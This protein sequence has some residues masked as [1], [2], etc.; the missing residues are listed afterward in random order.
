[1]VIFVRL[2]LPN[3]GANSRYP[4]AGP[5]GAGSGTISSLEQVCDVLPDIFLQSFGTEIGVWETDL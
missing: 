4:L 3:G 5:F 1:M 2:A